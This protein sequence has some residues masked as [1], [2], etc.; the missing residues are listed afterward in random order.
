MLVRFALV[1]VSVLLALATLGL[2]RDATGTTA[3]HPRLALAGAQPLTVSGRHFRA[4]ERVSLVLHQASGVTR[5]RARAGRDGGF[6]KV[7]TGVTTDRC[8]GFQ[9]TAKGS[10]GSRAT[11]LHR[12]LPQCPPA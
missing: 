4:H 11:L 3:H 5:R 1:S 9:L 8:S 10:A 12:A 2:A 6:R 7:F